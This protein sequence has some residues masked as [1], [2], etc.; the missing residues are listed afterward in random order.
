MFIVSYVKAYR[1]KLNYT[2][3]E[4][5]FLCDVSRQ[6]INSIENGKSTPNIC[7]AYKIAI[8]LDVPVEELFEL[9]FEFHKKLAC[10]RD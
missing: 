4:L 5:A 10:K 8:A 7:L 1:K 6:T 3:D 9:V 2:Q